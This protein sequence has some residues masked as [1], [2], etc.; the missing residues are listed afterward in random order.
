MNQVVKP[1]TPEEAIKP[2]TKA[3]DSY[4]RNHCPDPSSEVIFLSSILKDKTQNGLRRYYAASLLTEKVTGFELITE[5]W[6][7]AKLVYANFG[8]DKVNLWIPK[9]PT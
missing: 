1:T 8:S 2:H 4:L 3:V 7:G 6:Q 9:K 5:S